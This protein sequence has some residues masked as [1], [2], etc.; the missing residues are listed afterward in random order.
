MNNDMKES[1]FKSILTW[2]TLLSPIFSLIIFICNFY[3]EYLINGFSKYFGIVNFKLNVNMINFWI[4]LFICLFYIFLIFLICLF[5]KKIVS[6]FYDFTFYISLL[7]LVILTVMK[8][9]FFFFFKQFIFEELIFLIATICL[10]L[11][12]NYY[13]CCHEENHGC[14][15]MINF[16]FWIFI[17]VLGFYFISGWKYLV[18]IS[19][20]LLYFLSVPLIAD[21]VSKFQFKNEKSK[22]SNKTNLDRKFKYCISSFLCF[23]IGIVLIYSGLLIKVLF[24]DA[25][26]GIEKIGYELATGKNYFNII[27]FNDEINK[28]YILFDSTDNEYIFIEVINQYM[29]GDDLILEIKGDE[30]MIKSNL[31]NATITTNLAYVSIKKGEQ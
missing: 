17:S 20:I 26:S 28:K 5:L 6:L 29:D 27:L 13:L 16:I 9:F 31:D 10:F 7:F 23:V 12:I 21:F 18:V 4:L 22:E 25:R 15:S 8:I 14:V 11:L 30:F 1:H 2:I 19:L 24:Y 3:N